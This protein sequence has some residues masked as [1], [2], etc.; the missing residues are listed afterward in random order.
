MIKYLDRK[1]TK[2]EISQLLKHFELPQNETALK[3]AILQYFENAEA[4]MQGDERKEEIALR[5][6]FTKLKSEIRKYNPSSRIKYFQWFKISA[7][8]AVILVLFSI[9]IYFFLNYQNNQSQQV[10]Q[11]I[12]QDIKPGGNKAILTLANNQKIILT[13]VKNGQLAQQG[14]I[15]IHKTK[16]GLVV[17]SVSAATSQTGRVSSAKA[18]AYNTI[19]TPRGGQYQVIL[20]DGSH[21]WLNSASSIKY[22]ITFAGNNR[23]VK[24]TGEAYF[25]VAHNAAKPFSVI[26]KGQT[27]RVLGTHFNINAYGDEQMIK[28]TLLEGSVRVTANNNIHILKPGE[29]SRLTLDGD[30]KVN[31]A[32]LAEAVAWKN[33]LFY[34][35]NT[36]LQNVM[37]QL[38]RWYGVEIDYEGKI[39]NRTFTGAIHR[40]VNVSE[41]LQILKYTKVNFKI[42]GKKIVVTP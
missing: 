20:P 13:D 40:D 3:A 4:A 5:E 21:V 32:N 12:K 24:I 11:I 8:A 31:E 6:V 36:S 33:G 17:Y 30:L 18:T 22:P 23:E 26:T 27:V 19:S 39:P 42:N 10:S 16:D 2:E 14:N 37:R 15:I 28:T 35:E 9:S 7:V 41:V 1:C 29:Q 25:E 34:F 38:A